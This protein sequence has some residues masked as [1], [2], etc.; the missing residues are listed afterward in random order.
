MKCVEIAKHLKPAKIDAE[1]LSRGVAKYFFEQEAKEFEGRAKRSM[2][3]QLE[4]LLAENQYGQS[5][6][7]EEEPVFRENV[8]DKTSTLGS[9]EYIYTNNADCGLF[10]SIIT[11]YNKH[12]KLRTCAEDWWFVVTRRVAIAIDKNSKKETVRKMFVDHEGRCP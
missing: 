1:H 6:V 10:A 9:E 7:I 12:W 3:E 8:G 11:A 4:E 2:E 5:Q